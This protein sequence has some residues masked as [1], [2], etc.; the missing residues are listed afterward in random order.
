MAHFTR[1]E[2]LCIFTPLPPKT[3]DFRY[4]WVWFSCFWCTKHKPDALPSVL[5]FCIFVNAKRQGVQIYLIKSTNESFIDY[6]IYYRHAH[7]FSQKHKNAKMQRSECRTPSWLGGYA[8][9]R[10][11]SMIEHQNA[12]YEHKGKFTWSMPID[13]ASKFLLHPSWCVAWKKLRDG[14]A[15]KFSSPRKKIWHLSPNLP[16]PIKFYKISKNNSIFILLEQNNA[17]SLQRNSKQQNNH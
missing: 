5:Y 12:K 15:E 4:F 14:V 1:E 17:I 9:R 10:S 7:L 13:E 6:Y 2:F 16:F 3:A 11:I 8:E